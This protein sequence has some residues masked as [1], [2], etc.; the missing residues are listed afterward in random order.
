[1]TAN[2]DLAQLQPHVPTGL[3]VPG[4]RVLVPMTRGARR[5]LRPGTVVPSNLRR[6]CKVR[7]DR[8]IPDNVPVE[9]LVADLLP[10]VSNP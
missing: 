3:A 7:L 4:T 2:P 9:V 5:V 6:Y 8:V 10:V 1:M